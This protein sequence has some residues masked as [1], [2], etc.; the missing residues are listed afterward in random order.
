MKNQTFDRWFPGRPDVSNISSLT[1]FDPLLILAGE[2]ATWAVTPTNDLP[3][4]LPLAPGWNSVCYLGTDKDAGEA[5]SQIEGDFAII[6]SLAPDQ[7]W[8]RYVAGR[9]EVSNLT[10]LEKYASVLIL[11]TDPDGAL[12]VFNP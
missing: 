6:Y 2:S 1:P 10:R 3:D 7:S 12:W 4:S 9:P 11:V 8:R 5:V